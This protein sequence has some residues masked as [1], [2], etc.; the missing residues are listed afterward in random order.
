[1]GGLAGTATPFGDPPRQQGAHLIAGEHPVVLGGPDARRT[2]VGVGIVRD[3]HVGTL[4]AGV[5]QCQIHR[6]GFLGIG[7]VDR[8]EAT[9]GLELGGHLRR[10]IESGLA[11]GPHEYLT[12]D[13][14]HGGIDRRDL[15][16]SVA[17]K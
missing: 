5:G 7:E 4:G 2:A 1:M 3:D 8:G 17:E 14:V 12:A 15:T 9:V 13:T 16:G 6:T 10:R 11:Y